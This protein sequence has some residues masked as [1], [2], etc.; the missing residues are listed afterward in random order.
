MRLFV[1]ASFCCSVLVTAGL[2]G[3]PKLSVT[4]ASCS[5]AKFFC[6]IAKFFYGVAKFFY[7][8]T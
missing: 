8:V 3:P 1:T 6:G 4:A 5:V 2:T 7:D